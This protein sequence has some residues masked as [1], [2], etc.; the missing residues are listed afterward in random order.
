LKKRGYL[1]VKEFFVLLSQ[2]VFATVN[3]LQQIFI[4]SSALILSEI[5]PFIQ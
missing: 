4:G 5:Y 3:Q 2:H 1:T